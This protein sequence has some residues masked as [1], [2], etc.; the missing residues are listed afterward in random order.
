[1]FVL[2]RLE[3]AFAATEDAAEIARKSAATVV[4]Q[5][6]ALVKAAQTGNLAAIK[7]T[8]DRLKASADLLVQ[9]INAAT[10]AWP[11]SDDEEQALFEVQYVS[12]L[13]AAADELGLQLYE[14]DGLLIS[15][16]SIIRILANDRAVRVDRKKVSTVRPSYLAALLQKNQQKSSS[17]SSQRFLEA[18]YGVY[19]D[20]AELHAGDDMLESHSGPVVPLARIYKLMTSLPGASREYDRS[21]FARDLYFLDANGPH[22]T[23]SGATVSFPA[24]TG[25]RQRKSDL[26]SF[27]GPD[28]DNVEFYGIRFQ[29]PSR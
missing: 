20:I 21:D 17:F 26:F 2:D 3:Q 1:M 16:P 9:D 22:A 29:E 8:Q 27:I 15:Y 23:R 28:G 18:M 11:L 6:R 10:T 12:L 25:T 24:S 7:R 4:S 19:N 5:S 14:R 13:Q